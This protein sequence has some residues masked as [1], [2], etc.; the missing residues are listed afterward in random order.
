MDYK[1]VKKLLYENQDLKYRQFHAGLLNNKMVKLIGVRTPILR[2]IA[3][4]ISKNDYQ[5]FIKNKNH[6]FYEETI[7]HG[8]VLGYIKVGEAELINMVDDF[9]PYIDNWAVNDIVSANLKA[10]KNIDI[11]KI[12]K[13]I[14]SSNPWEVRFGLTLLLNHYI[15]KNNL[16]IIYQICD[17]IKSDFYYVKMANAWLLS[18]CYIKYPK[19]TLNY[20]KRANLDVFTYN[21]TISKICDSFRV[22]K[23]DKDYLK[24]LRRN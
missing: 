12:N 18:I 21:K 14:N 16:K 5:S 22:K 23:E 19:E 1:N 15:N 8:L 9:I 6:E 4:D 3:K 10:F 13:Y 11:N 24:T 7:L 2:K 17:N 20:L